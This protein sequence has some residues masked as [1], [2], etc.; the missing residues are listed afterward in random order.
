MMFQRNQPPMER[1]MAMQF[2]TVL[3]CV[4]MNLSGRLGTLSRRWVEVGEG[5]YV[6]HLQRNEPYDSRI[7]DTAEC[8][9]GV[10]FSEK[11]LAIQPQ[12]AEIHHL[13]TD[14]SIFFP[15]A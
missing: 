3:E 9:D 2:V 10:I 15:R 8:K 11:R 6:L 12:H 13:S 1:K 14:I 5:K 4:S 7:S